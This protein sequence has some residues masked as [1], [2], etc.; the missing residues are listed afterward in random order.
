MFNLAYF[1]R[2]PKFD[3]AR[4]SGIDIEKVNEE[5]MLNMYELNE[6]TTVAWNA[7]MNL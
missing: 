7:G 4:E 3:Q 5:A 6:K 2:R 1:H